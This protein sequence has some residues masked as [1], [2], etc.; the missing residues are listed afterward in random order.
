MTTEYLHVKEMAL[1]PWASRQR[2]GHADE[3]SLMYVRVVVAWD[4]E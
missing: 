2:K 3:E 4:D 1:V